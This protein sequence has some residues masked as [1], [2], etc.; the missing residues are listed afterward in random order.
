[1]RAGRY[2]YEDIMAFMP[3]GWRGKAKELGALK[4]AREIK[5]AEDLLRVI[6]LYL[7]EG[8][9]YAGTSALIGLAG[10][11]H[12]SWTGVYQRILNSEVWLKWLCENIG[13]GGGLPGA[14]PAW[15]AGKNV[16]VV[17]GSEA[18]TQG[19]EKCYYQLHYSLDLFTLSLRELQITDN[20]T[21][22]KMRNFRR[23]GRSD[24]VVGDRAYGTLLLAALCERP[25]NA[26]RSST[27][28]GT[29]HPVARERLSLWREVYVARVLLLK[30]L[31]ASFKPARLSTYLRILS[32]TCAD[33]KRKRKPQLF[34][35]NSS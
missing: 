5:T 35:F 15:L 16:C 26:G 13:R 32:W 31:L 10:D 9:S 1:M 7:T 23:L 3:E 19:T 18:V 30:A 29:A 12:L 2:R 25:V 4:R 6:F 14:K 33:S 24:V 21:G 11:F 20:K 34:L 8:R 22:E 17:D 28:S 27:P